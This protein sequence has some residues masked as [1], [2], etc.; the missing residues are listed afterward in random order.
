MGAVIVEEPG[1]DAATRESRVAARLESAWT[2]AQPEGS[3][4]ER[5]TSAAS[6][7]TNYDNFNCCNHYAVFGR[8]SSRSTGGDVRP[9]PA[10]EPPTAS[11]ASEIIP[12]VRFSHAAR[13]GCL[14]RPVSDSRAARHRRNGRSLPRPG[15]ATAPSPSRSCRAGRFATRTPRVAFCKRLKTPLRSSNVDFLAME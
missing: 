13:D 6:L 7:S 5:R 3:K 2:L 14:A 10:S 12:S 9:S 4:R 11:V 8:H 15:P 1:A